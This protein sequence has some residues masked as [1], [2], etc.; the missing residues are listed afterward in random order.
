MKEI[1][2]TLYILIALVC[3]II[4]LIS[5]DGLTKLVFGAFSLLWLIR[6]FIQMLSKDEKTD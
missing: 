5:I 3:F 4:S 1:K 2:E 6:S